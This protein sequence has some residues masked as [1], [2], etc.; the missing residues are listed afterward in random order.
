MLGISGNSPDARQRQNTGHTAWISAHERRL[1]R[2]HAIALEL[3]AS[4]R[5]YKE[6]NSDK[7]SP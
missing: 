7:P 2:G 5:Q 4:V 6:T 3:G 1:Y